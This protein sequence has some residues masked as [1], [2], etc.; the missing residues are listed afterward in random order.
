MN[1][2]PTRRTLLA[3]LTLLS[4]L[5]AATA[6]DWPRFRGPN[7]TGTAADASIPVQFK[8]DDG[9]LWKVALPGSGNSSPVVSHGKLFIQSASADGR[10][11]L[12]LCLDAAS[13]KTLWSRSLPGATAPTH[14]KN[15][16]ASSTPA[17]DGERVYA[18]FWDGAA[19]T[20]AAFDFQGHPLWKQGL[21]PYQSQHGAGVSPVVYDGRVYVNYDQDFLDPKGKEI[22]GAEHMTGLFAF[23]A[24]TGKLLWRQE[25]KPFRACYSSPLIREAPNGS[26]ELIVATTTAITGYD[27]K[28][29]AVLWNWE[30]DWSYRRPLRAVASPTVYDD[31][32]FMQTGDGDGSNRIVAVKVPGPGGTPE[33]VWEKRKGTA[34]VPT[35]LVH[36]GRLFLATDRGLA[37]C[38]DARTGAEI[39]KEERLGGN[40][41][42]SPVLI[43]GKVYVA[44]EEGDVFVFPAATTFKLLAHNRLG[45]HII[46][47]PAVADGRLYIRGD[48]HLFCI[49]KK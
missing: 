27:P 2:A 23:D 46:A 16:L 39:W 12:L 3:A 13:G 35:L 4:T 32:V 19:M 40:I 22:P 26:K 24:Q 37:S 41:T 45:E 5:A 20:L 1:H 38:F 21:G 36:D 10:E 8:E 43:D 33:M 48:K 30:P 28:T 34:Y 14:K 29:G 49:G 15:T 6:A 47:T 25:R 18:L 9:I 42:S 44:S 11:R 31:M 7:G 17:A